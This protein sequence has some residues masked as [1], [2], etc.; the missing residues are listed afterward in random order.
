[1]KVQELEYSPK[2]ILESYDQE[3]IE[4][5]AL[6]MVNAIKTGELKENTEQL[7]Q[8]ACAIVEDFYNP[9]EK[10]GSVS[11]SQRAAAALYLDKVGSKITMEPSANQHKS[12]SPTKGQPE[13]SD[14]WKRKLAK[15]KAD[16]DKKKKGGFFSKLFSSQQLEGKNYTKKGGNNEHVSWEITLN[17]GKTKKVKADS[18]KNAKDQL[19][20]EQLIVGVKSITKITEGEKHGN[21]KEYDRC[22][23]GYKKVPGKKRG[24][25]GSCVKETELNEESYSVYDPK[26]M[27]IV[28]AGLTRARA[29]S[30]V[31]RKPHLKMG[32]GGW[33]QDQQRRYATV[34]VTEVANTV[35][36]GVVVIEDADEIR[37][38]YGAIQEAE[39]Q[40]QKVELNK[41]IRSSNG[42]KK[43][44]VYVKNDKG[45]VV[46][47]NF[48]DPKMKIKKNIPGARK[49][50]R[51]RHKCDQKKDKTTAGYWSCKMW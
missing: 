35:E 10:N 19:S 49:S 9:D 4:N 50:F 14:K 48:G 6:E 8:I 51:A 25:K 38:H 28:Q 37:I 40:G 11:Q 7:V 3:Q 47:V 17:N 29:K 39:Y 30:I 21:S 23:D 42:P 31:S 44:H 43:F 46:K 12:P 1:M 5:H 33:V 13:I 15:T 41:P 27:K 24:E 2:Q 16:M 26:T 20:S 32:S 22:W 34:G 36:S 18:K 45:N